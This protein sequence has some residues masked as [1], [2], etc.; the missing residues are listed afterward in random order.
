ML[1]SD[2]IRISVLHMFLS[3]HDL[4]RVPGISQCTA[5][6]VSYL[7]GQHRPAWTS[8]MFTA[9]EVL[10]ACGVVMSK[11]TALRIFT[12]QMFTPDIN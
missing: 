5:R 2:V 12:S 10:H 11:L 7:R 3:C 4:S 8:K 9:F 6:P 1:S